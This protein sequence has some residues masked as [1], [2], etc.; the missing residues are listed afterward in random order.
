LVSFSPQL[1]QAFA[2]LAAAVHF[3]QDFDRDIFG[4][5]KD[6]GQG[7]TKSLRNV[8]IA[9]PSIADETVKHIHATGDERAKEAWK[10][11]QLEMAEE[12]GFSLNSRRAGFSSP[13]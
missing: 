12:R 1:T 7:K 11:I 8:L 10:E 6:W 2:D 5:V 13:G 9:L 4:I 3:S